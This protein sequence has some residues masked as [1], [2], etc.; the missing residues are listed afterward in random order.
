MI[1][2]AGINSSMISQWYESAL[3]ESESGCILV[4]SP[5]C[6]RGGS[7]RNEAWAGGTRR[8]ETVGTQAH[9]A[10]RSP[11]DWF[12]LQTAGAAGDEPVSVPAATRGLSEVVRLRDSILPKGASLWDDVH[13]KTCIQSI[14]DPIAG[15]VYNAAADLNSDGRINGE[16]QILSSYIPEHTLYDVESFRY[17]GNGNRVSLTQNGDEYSYEYGVRNQLSKVWLKKKGATLKALFAEY[18]Y[19]ANGNTTIR[20]IHS[21]TG[22]KQTTFSYDTLN[23]L[24][25]TDDGKQQTVYTYDNAGNRLYKQDK[26][27]LTLYLRHGQIAVAMDVEVYAPASPEGATKQGVVNR[28]VLS[29]DFLAGRVQTATAKLGTKTTI[30]SYYHLDHLNST[31]VVSDATGAVEVQYVYRAFGEQLRKLGAGD[32]TYTY[33]GKEL[34]DQTNL[35]YFNARY[36]DATTGRF[37]NVDP[38]Q[39]G[40]NWYVY[41]SNNPLGMVDPTGLDPDDVQTVTLNYTQ[42]EA[43]LNEMSENSKP[44]VRDAAVDEGIDKVVDVI[45]KNSKIIIPINQTAY[46][47]SKILIGTAMDDS[48]SR[49]IENTKRVGDLLRKIA[50]YDTNKQFDVDY[51]FSITIIGMENSSMELKYKSLEVKS[52]NNRTNQSSVDELLFNG[53]TARAFINASKPDVPIDSS[54]QAQTP[55]INSD[56]K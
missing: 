9:H 53:A 10:G 37:I 39:D 28:Y 14:G 51:S 42:M 11:A 32:A 49:Q 4:D 52:V 7:E 5:E 16:D 44:G 8:V 13:Q 29:G 34:D 43:A 40:T 41:C 19:D 27:G 54:T 17:D 46:M 12:C 47:A 1:K 50:K 15:V 38:I 36:Y 45:D 21:Q 48:T 25:M 35:Y 24:V 22:I 2:R 56:R 30:R 33:G 20:K 18:S 3:E 31:K 6:A 55:K 26:N 23:R